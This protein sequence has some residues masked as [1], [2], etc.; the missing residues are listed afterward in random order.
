[1]LQL[2]CSFEPDAL[3]YQMD[4]CTQCLGLMLDFSSQGLQDLT[5]VP[6]KFSSVSF[7]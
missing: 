2:T 7:R 6:L 1:M 4:N 5:G 3:S